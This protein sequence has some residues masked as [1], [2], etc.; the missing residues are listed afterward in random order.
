M[1]SATK[2]KETHFACTSIFKLPLLYSLAGLL[3]Q[4]VRLCAH[5]HTRWLPYP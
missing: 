4:G 1:V 3:K 5:A 2:A